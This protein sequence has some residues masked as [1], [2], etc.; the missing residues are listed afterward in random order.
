MKGESTEMNRRPSRLLPD[1]RIIV[2]IAMTL[3][4]SCTRTESLAARTTAV[5]TAS[6]VLG[7]PQLANTV[8]HW[9][10]KGLGG[11]VT[12]IACGLVVRGLVLRSARR[13]LLG[14][15]QVSR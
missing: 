2:V 11:T 13:T 1:V 5:S 10:W 4:T 7:P 6:E 9:F 3:A 12:A 8:H 15:G 14:P